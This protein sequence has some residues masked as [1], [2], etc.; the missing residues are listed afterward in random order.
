LYAIEASLRDL[1]PEARGL[2]RQRQLAPRLHALKHWL[3]D[4]QPKVLGNTGLAKAVNYTLRR[5]DALA[6]ILDAGRYP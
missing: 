3:D 2:Q 1:A 4:L 5:W 6:R